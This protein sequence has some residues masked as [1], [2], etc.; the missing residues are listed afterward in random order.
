MG[1]RAD[2]SLL[3]PITADEL[4]RA[5]I[6]D[7]TMTSPTDGWAVGCLYA[8]DQRTRQAGLILRY[9]DHQWWLVDDPLPVALLTSIAMLSPSDGWVTG[10]NLTR[11]D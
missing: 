7:L 11:N 10:N 2:M 6:V 5:A 9:Y 4:R 3:R 1:R 8:P